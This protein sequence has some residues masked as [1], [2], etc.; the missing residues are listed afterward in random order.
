ML[1]NAG[2]NL[3]RPTLARMLGALSDARWI[4]TAVQRIPHGCSVNLVSGAYTRP[5]QSAS[6][7]MSSLR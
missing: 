1:A 6:R 4:S 2:F 3:H 7:F 5:L